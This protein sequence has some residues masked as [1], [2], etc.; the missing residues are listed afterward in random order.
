MKHFF[1]RLGGFVLG[2]LRGFDRIRFRGTKIQLCYPNGI[3]GFLQSRSLRLCDFKAYAQEVTERLFQA[4]EPPA[5]QMGLYRYLITGEVRLEPVALEI[6]EQKRTEGLIAVL[7]RVEPCQ[8][9]EF[10]RG[11][12][13]RAT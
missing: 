9:I 2:L 3:T 13:C 12:I 1:Q 10:R 8:T 4:T 7:G 11:E 5:K 6:A